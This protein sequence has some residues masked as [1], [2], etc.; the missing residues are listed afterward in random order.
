MISYLLSTAANVPVTPMW[1]P[2]VAGII[3]GSS[4]VSL[5]LTTKVK[6]PNIGPKMPLVP[7]SI[8]AFVGAM[9]FGHILGIGIVLG[10][11]NIGTL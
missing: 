1:T 9:C 8:P 2:Q 11:T 6:Y 4:I 10:L 5:L 7:I 3:A